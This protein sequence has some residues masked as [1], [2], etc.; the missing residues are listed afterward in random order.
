M[1]AFDACSHDRREQLLLQIVYKRSVTCGCGMYVC[2]RAYECMCAH[3]YVHLM[4]KYLDNQWINIYN[5]VFISQYTEFPLSY[6][7][8]NKYMEKINT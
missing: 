1:I 5:C 6:F 3:I 7:Y 4:E 2:T 8:T